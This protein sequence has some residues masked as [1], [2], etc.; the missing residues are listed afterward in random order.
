MTKALGSG[1]NG[2]QQ[3]G[4]ETNVFKLRQNLQSQELYR[5]SSNGHSKQREETIKMCHLHRC[6]NVMS[7]FGNNRKVA[8]ATRV[9]RQ[10]ACRALVRAS[11]RSYHTVGVVGEDIRED[12]GLGD[13]IS[14]GQKRNHNRQMRPWE[15]N[16]Q[17][18]QYIAH[19]N[20]RKSKIQVRHKNKEKQEVPLVGKQYGKVGTSERCGN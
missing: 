16:M 17:K 6:T 5:K 10:A 11:F 4:I 2:V 8:L 3:N 13:C 14:K 12:R 18:K 9:R 19:A 20:R 7:K 1:S 15:E